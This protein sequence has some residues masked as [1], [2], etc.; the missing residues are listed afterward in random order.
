LCTLIVFRPGARACGSANLRSR[1][2]EK[3]GRIRR[4]DTDSQFGLHPHSE[5][6]TQE[7][8]PYALICLGCFSLVLPQNRH[9]ERSASPIDRLTQRLWR[10]VEGPRR[11]LSNP[12][13]SELFNHRNPAAN[14]KRPCMAAENVDVGAGQAR[15]WQFRSCRPQGKPCRASVAEKLRAA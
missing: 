6:I 13:C 5:G 1:P 3:L 4:H 14:V 11:C 7:A 12:C 15:C 9:P 8:I 2:R 10:G